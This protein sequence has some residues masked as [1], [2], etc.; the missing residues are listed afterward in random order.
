MLQFYR[1][2]ILDET[3]NTVAIKY[4]DNLTLHIL[5]NLNDILVILYSL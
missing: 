1:N 3:I 2:K 5:L 4:K